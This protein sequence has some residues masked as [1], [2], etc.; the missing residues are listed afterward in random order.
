ML[1]L[2]RIIDAIHQGVL[3]IE[4]NQA[5]PIHGIMV[6]PAAPDNNFSSP[7]DQIIV[8]GRF[9]LKPETTELDYTIQLF[10]EN[11][12]EQTIKIT[13]TIEADHFTQEFELSPEHPQERLFDPASK[14][15]LEVIKTGIS[16]VQM[17]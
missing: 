12:D 5:S 7:T 9:E 6:S 17:F 16:N 1:E 15:V 4:D 11:A 8:M 13:A 10:G 3:L 2:H 14:S